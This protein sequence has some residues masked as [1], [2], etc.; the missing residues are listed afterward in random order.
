MGK[1]EVNIKLDVTFVANGCV[2]ATI[3][4]PDSCCA[5]T[6]MCNRVWSFESIKGCDVMLCNGHGTDGR[7]GQEA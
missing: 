4:P 5:G 1:H 7:L 6:D 3:V 2:L